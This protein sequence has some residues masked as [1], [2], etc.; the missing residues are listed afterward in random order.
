MQ[1]LL[2]DIPIMVL[3][4][5]VEITSLSSYKPIFCGY[6]D[7]RAIKRYDTGDFLIYNLEGTLLFT[8]VCY[9]GEH[10]PTKNTAE[11]Q[12]LI[13]LLNWITENIYPI[14]TEQFYILGDLTLVLDFC[15]RR[16]NPSKSNLFLR[17]LYI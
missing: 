13:D 2:S 6:C 17:T 7:R 12:S 4:L 8:E 3:P 14:K 15:Y 9:Y 10:L 16:A 11:M 1:W 5:W